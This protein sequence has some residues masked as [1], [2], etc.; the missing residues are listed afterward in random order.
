M[1]VKKLLQ[2]QCKEVISIGFSEQGIKAA[3]VVKDDELYAVKVMRK[4]WPQALRENRYLENIAATAAVI[5]DM[6]VE[7]KLTDLRKAAFIIAGDDVIIRQISFPKMAKKELLEAFRWE[8]EQYIPYEE[9]ECYQRLQIMQHDDESCLLVKALPKSVADYLTAVSTAAGLELLLLTTEELAAGS[10]MT[11]QNEQLQPAF[12]RVKWNGSFLSEA[13]QQEVAAEYC[14]ELG[15][16]AAVLS[17]DDIGLLPE[18]HTSVEK[19]VL[20]KMAAAIYTAAI[21]FLWGG[22]YIFSCWQDFEL[23]RGEY[24]LNALSTWQQRYEQYT[25]QQEK[26]DELQQLADKLDK[27]RHQWSVLLEIFGS[28]IPKGC[29]INRIR[30]TDTEEKSIAIEGK[31]VDIKSIDDFIDRL[32]QHQELTAV[33]LK[34]TKSGDDKSQGEY[35]AYSIVLQFRREKHA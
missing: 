21:I 3:V 5:R 28:E 1:D 6:L 24:K 8:R 15:S 32:Q 4:E 26:I 11:E 19:T 30:E 7:H 23:E 2:K 13:Q 18:K 29:W 33:E 10:F 9:A 25:Q 27:D 20:F 16:G 17:G 34:S 12:D 14:C 22:A 31:A 35:V